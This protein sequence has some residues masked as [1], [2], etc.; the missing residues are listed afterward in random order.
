MN[1][2]PWAIIFFSMFFL[3]IPIFN[4]VLTYFFLE[5]H[6]SFGDYIY[7]LVY[8]SSN[9]FPLFNLTV[10]SLV[11]SYAV[12]SIKNWSIPVFFICMFWIL[13]NSVVDLYTHFTLIKSFIIILV[14]II[15]N[16]LFIYYILIPNVR[17][18]YLDPKLRWWES[19]PRYLINEQV[20]LNSEIIGEGGLTAKINNFSEG[21]L[22]LGTEKKLHVGDVVDV[23]FEVLKVS[24]ILR[25]KIVHH[26]AS[27][28]AYGLQFVDLKKEDK[29][30]LA[31]I[32]RELR[33]QN[34]PETRAKIDWRE[35]LK[36]WFADLKN[37][38]GIV[39]EISHK[40]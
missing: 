34:F 11:A 10:P 33:L 27:I 13:L 5:G 2:K 9:W 15:C 37:G 35:D 23:R 28:H 26:I 6:Y 20:E 24:F 19:K 18:A 8:L 25:G 4:I 21:G 31:K 3:L 12:Y 17:A 29:K 39:P 1:R 36:K 38:K 40:K 14:P 22:F 30:A 16:L 7:S 32:C